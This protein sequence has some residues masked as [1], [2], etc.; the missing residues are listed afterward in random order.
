MLYIW[1]AERRMIINLIFKLFKW[2]W[3]LWDRLDE[4][5]KRQI[6][7]VIIEAF[8]DLIRAFYKQWESKNKK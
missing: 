4:K 1:V 5:T 8:K 6:I 7:E 3:Q 2:F